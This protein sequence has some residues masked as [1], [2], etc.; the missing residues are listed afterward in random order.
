MQVYPFLP[1]RRKNRI[2]CRI[3]F[4]AG[5]T[6]ADSFLTCIGH[7]FRDPV[8]QTQ[9]YTPAGKPFAAAKADATAI[10]RTSAALDAIPCRLVWIQ[11]RSIRRT[12]AS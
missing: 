12:W 2:G 9:C 8:E 6:P 4:W 1:T 10:T 3:G 11:T 7:R 5:E